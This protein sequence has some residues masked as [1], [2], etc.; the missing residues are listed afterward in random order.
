MLTLIK[1]PVLQKSVIIG[2]GSICF[3]L[4]I[5]SFFQKTGISIMYSNSQNMSM[6]HVFNIFLLLFRPF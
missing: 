6:H 5:W 2:T 4:G 3:D 1:I